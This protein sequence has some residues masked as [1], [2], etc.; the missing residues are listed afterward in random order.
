MFSLNSP[1]L[2]AE[3]F[4]SFGP[5]Q[6][7]GDEPTSISIWHGNGDI[8]L[9]QINYVWRQTQTYS[10]EDKTRIVRDGCYDGFC[11]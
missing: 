7:A 10:A 3:W 8:V 1:I 2:E 9:M 11:G 5:A 6:N 4:R